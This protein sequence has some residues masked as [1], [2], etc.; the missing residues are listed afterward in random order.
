VNPPQKD[1]WYS[2]SFQSTGNLTISICGANPPIIRVYDA[3]SGCPSGAPLACSST[4]GFSCPG[5]GLPY[6]SVTV[7]FACFQTLL[8]QVGSPSATSDVSG[9]LSFGGVGTACETPHTKSCTGSGPGPACTGCNN[10]GC[11]T[12]GCANSAYAS[13]ASLRPYGIASVSSGT[14]DLYANEMTGNAALFIQSTGLSSPVPFGDGELCAAIGITRLGISN[15]SAPPYGF[16]H[17]PWGPVPIHVVGGP[18]QAG[19]VRHYQTWYRDA[20]P[21]C[22]GETFN[23]TNALTITWGP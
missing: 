3:I 22:T 11:S 18:L 17:F 14:L 12:C 13:G 20:V 7:G 1:L 19:D 8:V 9:T 21:Y 2:Q 23:L 10:P 16:A 4:S 6:T 5:S 15:V